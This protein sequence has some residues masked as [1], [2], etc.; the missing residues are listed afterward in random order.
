M[1]L[2]ALTWKFSLLTTLWHLSVYDWLYMHEYQK[3]IRFPSIK[4][5]L[6]PVHIIILNFNL[7]VLCR[8]IIWHGQKYFPFELI[9]ERGIMQPLVH[10]SFVNQDYWKMSFPV[11]VL[12]I[13][14]CL[15]YCEC[16]TVLFS[17]LLYSAKLMLYV[18]V[19]LGLFVC[20]CSFLPLFYPF[21]TPVILTG[22]QQIPRPLLRTCCLLSLQ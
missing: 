11:F 7:K 10:N 21:S 22:M 19:W 16:K 9:S 5:T 1:S 18:A 2:K 15:W 6:R 17:L 8:Y 20:F 4:W 13:F 14:N 3:E 12:K